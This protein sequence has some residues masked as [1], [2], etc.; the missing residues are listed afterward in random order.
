MLQFEFEDLGETCMPKG[1]NFLVFWIRK[2]LDLQL[3]RKPVST[4]SADNFCYSKVIKECHKFNLTSSNA[5]YRNLNKTIKCEVQK[6]I[7]HR[8]IGENM[9]N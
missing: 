2:S 3:Q 4:Q 7:N 6:I 1:I 5:Q 8:L 9:E